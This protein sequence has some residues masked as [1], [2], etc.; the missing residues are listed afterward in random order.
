MFSFL[1]LCALFMFFSDTGYPVFLDETFYKLFLLPLERTL[2]TPQNNDC[3]CVHISRSLV[4]CWIIFPTRAICFLC[5]Y[6][7]T[8]LFVF[9]KTFIAHFGGI[10]KTLKWI[11]F[12]SMLLIRVDEF[13]YSTFKI[14]LNRHFP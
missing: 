7:L 6:L 3:G 1:S 14:Y 2:P 5:I 12:I 4:F 13:R 9:I 8:A 10:W 11:A